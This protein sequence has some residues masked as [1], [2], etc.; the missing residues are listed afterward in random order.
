MANLSSRFDPISELVLASTDSPTEKTVREIENHYHVAMIADNSRALVAHQ[1]NVLKVQM[2]H[3][4]VSTQQHAQTNALL[5]EI[6][7]TLDDLL[8]TQEMV[9]EEI[10]ELRQTVAE[11]FEKVANEFLTSARSLNRLERP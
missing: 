8:Y 4:A 7:M 3:A 9:L 5:S 6:G 10:G 2:A 11:G 1:A